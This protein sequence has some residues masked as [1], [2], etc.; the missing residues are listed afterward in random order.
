MITSVP[1]NVPI[2]LLNGRIS[3]KTFKTYLRLSFIFAPLLKSF[4]YIIAKS[5][6][7]AEKFRK[8][9]KGQTNVTVGGNIKY[10]MSNEDLPPL[11]EN[12]KGRV[13]F[14]ASTHHPEESIFIQSAMAF[15]DKYDTIVIA[16]RHIRR[17]QEVAALVPEEL[18]EKTVIIDKLG[19][20]ETIYKVSDRIFVGGSIANIG[21]HNIFEALK[22]EK[23]VCVGVHNENFSDITP[24]AIEYGVATV[25]KDETEL[26][27]YFTVGADNIRPN[28]E[29]FFA[30]LHKDQQKY[31]DIINRCID[32][33]LAG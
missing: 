8:I 25:V 2:I 16:P 28:F 1:K 12:I 11:P 27:D 26:Q 21:G 20:L 10:Q 7:D 32:D 13:A 33:V 5:E 30:A 18:K 17:A 15:G 24:L 14:A 6:A 23:P 3:D 9:T 29:P 19:M 31:I 4:R 22:Y